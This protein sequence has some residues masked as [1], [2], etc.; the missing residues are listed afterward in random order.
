MLA[1]LLF[2][3]SSSIVYDFSQEGNIEPWQFYG[4]HERLSLEQSF[5]G[6]SGV[7][8]VH[9]AKKSGAE[10]PEYMLFNSQ[11]VQLNTHATTTFSIF[12]SAFTEGKV[13]F[14]ITCYA[15]DGTQLGITKDS[16]SI[17]QAGWHD[18]KLSVD[19]DTSAAFI[20]Y[21]LT[22]DAATT[23]GIDKITIQID[24]ATSDYDLPSFS[25]TEAAKAKALQQRV[26]LSDR[27]TLLQKLSGHSVI[28]LGESTHGTKEFIA[29]KQEVIRLL[30]EAGKLDKVYIEAAVGGI[31]AIDE[32]T[33]KGDTEI[34][35]LVDDLELWLWKTEEFKDFLKW[36]GNYN[37]A[38][39]QD[40]KI[41]LYGVDVQ[42]PRGNA[43]VLDRVRRDHKIKIKDSCQTMLDAWMANDWNV[44][45][46]YEDGKQ[47]GLKLAKDLE[48]AFALRHKD[49]TKRLGAA[50][51]SEIA[52][53]A[54]T[55]EEYYVLSTDY[56]TPLRDSLMA[57]NIS[58]P[59]SLGRS[60]VFWGHNIHVSESTPFTGEH[61]KRKFT[62]YLSVALMNGG[63]T[64]LATKKDS[65]AIANVNAI[66]NSIE[67]A[68]STVDNK[69]FYISVADLEGLDN[70][71]AMSIGLSVP[72]FTYLSLPIPMLYDA[73]LYS[74]TSTAVT[75]G[76]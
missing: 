57:H 24:G 61:L 65:L 1:L 63:G 29:M 6:R 31:F 19:I 14:S 2:L 34:D 54:K 46:K 23:I 33:S 56:G 25:L 62:D 30:A 70:A 21:L 73:I 76:R 18:V 66:P 58:G 11:S 75:L 5:E 15:S 7:L 13:L 55:F 53:I 32:I 37:R 71:L 72:N 69:P 60:V 59:K 51:A 52:R 41:R 22:T 45:R 74:P 68:L 67:H 16:T 36:V 50:E 48:A 44:L 12:T 4:E 43:K 9:P 38:A 40:R 26:L 27:D 8:V 17:S 64:Y 10:R 42:F 28:G 49:I 35:S 3:L 39:P 47:E 20:Q